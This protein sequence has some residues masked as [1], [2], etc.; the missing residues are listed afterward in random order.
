MAAPRRT[1]LLLDS[2]TRLLRVGASA[3]LL[4]LLQKQH[5]TDIAEILRRLQ[6][7]YRRMAFD[8]LAEHFLPN[9]YDP[10]R[11][12]LK[13]AHKDVSLATQVGKE[14]GVPMRLANLTL[15]EMT[16]ALGRGWQTRDSRSSMILQLE[17][18]GVKIAVDPEDLRAI[19]R[20]DSNS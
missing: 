1:D 10:A 20:A 8:T 16:E 18:S 4:N 2:V 14:M 15:E 3:N 17:R 7:H 12:A 19:L 9:H 11:F 13:L 6:P 5:P